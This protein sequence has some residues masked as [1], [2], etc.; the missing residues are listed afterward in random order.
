MHRLQAHA[1]CCAPRTMCPKLPLP[2]IPPKYLRPN[3]LVRNYAAIGT[4]TSPLW[5]GTTHRARAVQARGSGISV[6]CRHSPFGSFGLLDNF[7][8]MGRAPARA[9]VPKRWMSSVNS[10]EGVVPEL[11]RFSNGPDANDVFR[12]ENPWDSGTPIITSLEQTVSEFEFNAGCSVLDTKGNKVGGTVKMGLLLLPADPLD[13]ERCNKVAFVL[14]DNL[15]MK[16][17]NVF[18]LPWNYCS[19]DQINKRLEVLREQLNET[20]KEKRRLDSIA[21]YQVRRNGLLFGAYLSAQNALLAFCVF[22]VY[23]WDVMEPI[24][25][26]LGI[27]VTCCSAV[28]FGLKKRDMSSY[29]NLWARLL[30]KRRFK[31]YRKE[32]FNHRGFLELT[33]KIRELEL[34]SR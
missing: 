23:S 34:V 15:T 13:S 32:G 9:N 33:R 26:F 30:K 7:G 5:A 11:E 31:L 20:L 24:C 25:Y 14:R 1:A 10:V 2:K 8:D 27:S 6:R 12:L 16:E 19:D 4:G 17:K 22:G 29:D 28:Y 3:A 21:K 18:V